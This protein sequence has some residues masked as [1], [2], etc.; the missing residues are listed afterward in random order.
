MNGLNKILNKH[1]YTLARRYSQ[2][3]CVTGFKRGVWTDSIKFSQ[4][5]QG[6]CQFLRSYCSQV[7]PVEPAEKP[8]EGPYV[9][10][11]DRGKALSNF[12]ML[13]LVKAKM[14]P[15]KEAIP[16]YV[17]YNKLHQ[18]RDWMRIYICFGMCIATAIGYV[19]MRWVGLR[20]AA[21]GKMAGVMQMEKIAT[22][23]QQGK[24]EEAAAKAS[25][26]AGS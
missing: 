24:A 12:D 26:S 8:K 5:S 21:Q 15:N 1:S 22:L 11:T 2:S 17:S 3:V 6:Q 10:K 9:P 23:R 4:A 13:C 19:I 18:A 16:E 25:S 7:T 14:Y 20:D